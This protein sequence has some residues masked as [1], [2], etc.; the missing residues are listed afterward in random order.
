MVHNKTTRHNSIGAYGKR[1]KATHPLQ[2]EASVLSTTTG[3]RNSVAVRQNEGVVRSFLSKT[4]AD[5]ERNWTQG[6]HFSAVAEIVDTPWR[7]Q[8]DAVRYGSSKLGG[9]IKRTTSRA[10]HSAL[11][12]TEN[13]ARTVAPIA[14][15]GGVFLTIAVI[16]GLL[17]V[18]KITKTG[19]GLI[20]KI[21]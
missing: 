2:T 5:A 6:R 18:L 16:A 15:G 3:K 9:A 13:V 21:V 17:I 11:T 20:D 12:T 14:I 8:I 7:A 19:S 1:E 10:Y 4:I